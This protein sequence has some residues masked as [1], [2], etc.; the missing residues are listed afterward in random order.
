MHRLPEYGVNHLR[1][2]GP[3]LPNKIPLRFVIVVAVRPEIHHL[4]GDNLTLSL[5]LLLILNPLVF[6]NPVHELAYTGNDFP[7]NDL[8]HAWQVSRP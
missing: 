1:N 4:L 5:A 2:Y 3:R 6:I 8:I 7:V